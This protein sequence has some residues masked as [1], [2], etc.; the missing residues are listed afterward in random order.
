[1]HQFV[2]E[3]CTRDEYKFVHLEVIW[4][5]KCNHFELI[6]GKN[7]IAL[8][9]NQVKKLIY[10]TR[11]RTFAGNEIS[12]VKIIIKVEAQWSGFSK[13]AFICHHSSFVVKKEMQ[14][15]MCFLVPQLLALLMYPMVSYFKW[16]CVAI[17]DIKD[18]LTML[19]H[20]WK[21]QIFVYATFNIVLHPCYQW[22]IGMVFYAC[23]SIYTCIAWA[24]MSGKIS[25]CYRQVFNLLTSS[26]QELDP[27][28]IGV[29][30]E[31]V[32]IAMLQS[33]SLM[34]FL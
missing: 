22:L 30:F 34:L 17:F 20:P 11:N 23:R 28:Y 26:V 5:D 25:K 6:A 12:K 19:C 7:Y 16:G 31:Y 10:N 8:I 24:L 9:M 13:R 3:R 21:V 14:W 27:S 18:F 2:E 33:I 4:Q 32:F 1:M 15:I 29:D